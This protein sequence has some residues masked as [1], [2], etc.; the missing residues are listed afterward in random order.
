M[1]GRSRLGW[2]LLG[3]GVAAVAVLAYRNATAVP[4]GNQ[5]DAPGRTA[6]RW[7]WGGM[8][9]DGYSVTITRPR[10]ELYAFWRRFQNL[11]QVMENVESVSESGEEARWTIRAPMD[12]TVEVVTRVVTDRPDEV[13][14]WASVEGSEI[15]TS[16]KVMF[17][18]HPGG[19]GTVV[20]AIIAW[21]PPFGMLGQLVAK[22]A[23]R[24][25]AAQSRHELKRFKMLMETGEI[26]TAQSRVATT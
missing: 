10:P 12:R 2:V 18:D 8:A 13:I 20:T 16:G 11:P 6:R 26:A 7:R 9:V 22:V 3:G 14:A 23:G 4:R 21:N 5:D 25:P 17:A 15:E 24:E 19:R 1:D